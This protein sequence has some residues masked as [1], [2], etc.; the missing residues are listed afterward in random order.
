M[1]QVLARICHPFL[2]HLFGICLASNPMK[3]VVQFHGISNKTITLGK[4]LAH[5]PLRIV[6]GGEWF[7]LTT[8]L[9]EAVEYLH[10]QADTPRHQA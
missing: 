7:I 6:E 1:K 3:I 8:Q 10:D 5:Q 4:Q 9:L 2:P